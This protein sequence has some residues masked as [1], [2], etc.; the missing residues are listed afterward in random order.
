MI[1]LNNSQ[2][3]GSKIRKKHQRIK[4]MER[5]ERI[6]EIGFIRSIG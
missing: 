2:D 3:A 5:M 6:G 1:L 4:Q